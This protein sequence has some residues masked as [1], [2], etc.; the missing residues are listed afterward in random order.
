MK[1]PRTKYQKPISNLPFWNNSLKFKACKSGDLEYVQKACNSKIFVKIPYAW[2]LVVRDWATL[3][4]HKLDLV[5]LTFRW[6]HLS[7]DAEA[8]KQGITRTALIQGCTMGWNH[9]FLIIPWLVCFLDAFVEGWI[10]NV[11]HLLPDLKSCVESSNLCF[12][13]KLVNLILS[14]DGN[15]IKCFRL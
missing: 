12:V 14:Y 8:K 2:N 7:K 11:N 1:N 5:W 3:S 13:T 15:Q 9:L 4:M 10:L 6:T